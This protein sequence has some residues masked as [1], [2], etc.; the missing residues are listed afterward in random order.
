MARRVV[1]QEAEARLEELVSLTIGERLRFLWYRLLM[2]MGETRCTTYWLVACPYVVLPPPTD[3]AERSG[4][5][6]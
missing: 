1:R 2:V 5:Q 3:S 6:D 4:Q